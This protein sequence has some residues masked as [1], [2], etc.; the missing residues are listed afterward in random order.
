MGVDDTDTY[1]TRPHTPGQLRD[2]LRGRELTAVMRRGKTIWVET[3]GPN[4]D[5][6]PGPDLGVHLGM[7][8]SIVITAPGGAATRGPASRSPPGEL[9]PAPGPASP[10][11]TVSRWSS[12]T[13]AGWPCS[14]SAAWPGCGW[15]SISVRSGPTPRKVTPEQFRRPAQ[16][17]DDRGQGPAAGPVQDRRGREPAGGRDALAGQDLPRGTG[18][19]PSP[20]RTPPALRRAAGGA[21]VRRRPRRRAHRRGDPVPA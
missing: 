15:T 8:G 20:P 21:E 12:P 18:G 14:T 6:P 13:A 17:G 19:H 4:G 1:V 16:P 7:S 11:G 5:P 9:T 2:A 10:S 3:S